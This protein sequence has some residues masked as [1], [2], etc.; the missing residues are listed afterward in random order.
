MDTVLFPE[1]IPPEFESPKS[2]ND[3]MEAI[4]R[5]ATELLNKSQEEMTAIE[6]SLQD[7][8]QAVDN[9]EDT[10]SNQVTPKTVQSGGEIQREN[11]MDNVTNVDV[12]VDQI[13]A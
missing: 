10:R 12:S 8:S 11:S 9:I 13:S 3:E 6:N 1:P 7:L 5:E 4:E 2:N